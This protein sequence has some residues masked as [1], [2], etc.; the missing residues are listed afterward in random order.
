MT[1]VV[2]RYERLVAAGELRPD[3][4]Q[5]AAAA[6]LDRLAQEL[7]AVPSRGSILWRVLRKVPEPPRGVYLWGGVGRGKSMLMDLFFSCVEG[8]PKR[9][10]AI[11]AASPFG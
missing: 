8:T 3:R 6:R 11:F 9:R 7:A 2:A 10:A 4:E 5:A 1:G